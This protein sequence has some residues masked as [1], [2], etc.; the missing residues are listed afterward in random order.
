MRSVWLVAAMGGCASPPPAVDGPSTLRI[1]GSESLTERLLPALARTHEEAVG[2]LVFDIE[3]GGSSVGM[4]AMLDGDAALAASSRPPLP[5]EEEQARANGYTLDGDDARHVVAVDVVAV[6]V[7][8]GNLVDSLTYDQVIGI[9]CTGTIDNWSYLG[10]DPAPIRALTRDPSSGTR[11]LFEDFFCGPRGMSARVETS[12]MD[13]LL[14]ALASDPTAITFISMSEHAGKVVGLRPDPR[15]PALLPSQ[16]NI[17]RGAYPLYHDVMLYSP[18]PPVG[19]AAEFLV[20][21]ASPSGQ[22]VVDE[23][24]FVPLF[25]RPDRLDDPRP[26]RETVHFEAGSARLTDR[27]TARLRLVVEELTER[28]GETRHIVLE[29]YTDAQ[30]PDATE[31]S[32]ARSEAVKALL[33]AEIPGLYFEIIPR[34]PIRPLAPNETPYGRERNRRVQIYLANEEDFELHEEPEGG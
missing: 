3:G 20:W 2:T 10:L 24:R 7:H 19:P 14:G 18:G 1:V 32:R 11:A 27:S 16:Q 12:T 29:G 23:S 5:A 26:L 8:P 25:L 22:E 28:A 6:A 4:R 31:L 30:E 17:L 9:F 15:G 34:G 21:V 33:E 13:G